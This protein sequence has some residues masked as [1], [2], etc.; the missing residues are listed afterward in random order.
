MTS[1]PV[2]CLIKARPSRLSGGSWREHCLEVQLPYL[3]TVLKDFT[4]VPLIMGNPESR[5]IQDLADALETIP[6]D[7]STIMIAATDWQHYMRA[8]EGWEIRL[9]RNRLHQQAGSRKA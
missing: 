2:N 6:A 9:T 7:H 8:S 3:Q 4:L 5:T 1:Y